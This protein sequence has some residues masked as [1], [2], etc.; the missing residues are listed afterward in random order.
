MFKNPYCVGLS[1]LK[2]QKL[3]RA[4]LTYDAFTTCVL[5]NVTVSI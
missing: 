3:D 5:T 1:Q 4:T 2:N